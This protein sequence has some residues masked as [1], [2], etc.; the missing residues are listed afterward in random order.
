MPANI[1]QNT[2]IALST[3]IVSWAEPT[4]ND[5]AGPQT[6]TSSHSSGS[7]FEIGETIV[8]YTSTDLAGN[9][10]SETFTVT[11]LGKVFCFVLFCLVCLFVCF[12]GEGCCCFLFF[13][14]FC[15]Y[16]LLFSFW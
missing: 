1:N 5:N 15:F 13:N 10:M 3:A 2:D 4:A 6:L 12:L 16:F 9:T 8:T 7:P 14:L 11:V